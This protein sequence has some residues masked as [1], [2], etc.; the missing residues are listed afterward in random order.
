[1][2]R[3]RMRG[4]TLVELTIALVLLALLAGVLFGSLNLAGTSLDRGEAKVDATSGMRLA[5][6]FLRTNLEAQH[7]LRMRK[8]VEFPLLFAGQRDELRYAAALPTRVQDGGI[9]YFRLSVNSADA[10]SPLV[11][12]RALPDLSDTKM[13]E[14]NDAERSI[15]AQ[16][17]AELKLAY[18]GRDKDAND[19]NDPTWRDR[20]DDPQRLPLL[21]RIE[22]VPKKGPAW[23]VLIVAPRESPE[24]GCR[25]W[26]GARL[27]CASL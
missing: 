7:P 22:V 6:A 3:R 19:A 8:I 25:A 20:W 27:R 18:F 2:P 16:D 10:R 13:P 14:F 1:M 21:I 23:P 11:L 15:L 24:A 17:I 5:E 26:D 4:F 12:E 9:W